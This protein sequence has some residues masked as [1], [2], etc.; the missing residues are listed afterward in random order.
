MKW[1]V[2]AEEDS[3]SQVP[4]LSD[5]HTLR[6]R[7]PIRSLPCRIISIGS[8]GTTVR[9]GSTI[10]N[11]GGWESTHALSLFHHNHVLA[12]TGFHHPHLPPLLFGNRSLLTTPF[13]A[14][15]RDGEYH[16]QEPVSFAGQARPSSSNEDISPRLSVLAT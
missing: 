8:T 11:I 15:S 10:V 5:D 16:G 1:E 14:A 6:V 2:T 13:L 4:N 7:L 9:H 3:R 12:N